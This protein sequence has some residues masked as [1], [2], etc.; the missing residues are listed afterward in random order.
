VTS[1]GQQATQ[2]DQWRAEAERALSAKEW[3]AAQVAIVR[4]R[5]VAP[6]DA[7]IYEIEARLEQVLPIQRVIDTKRRRLNER[8]LQAAQVGPLTDPAISMEIQDLESEIADLNKQVQKLVN[9]WPQP[10]QR[11]RPAQI[12]KR[13]RIDAAI[14][15]QATLGEHIYLVVQVRLPNSRP[16]RLED[17]PTQTKPKA[18]EQ[19]SESIS[20]RFQASP[21]TDILA[22][23]YQE[24]KIIAPDF[25]IE[26]AASQTVEIPQNKSSKSVM[27]LLTPKR[28]GHIHVHIEV[29]SV[30]GV[31]DTSIPLAVANMVLMVRVEPNVVA[32]LVSLT[33]VLKIAVGIGLIIVA[34][35]VISLISSNSRIPAQGTANTPTGAPTAAPVVGGSSVPSA[36]GAPTATAAASAWRCTAP[37]AAPTVITP[38]VPAA[39]TTLTGPFDYSQ[40]GQELA[41]AFAGNYKGKTVSVLHG[42]SGEEERK[43]KDTFT[44]FE[45][46]TGIT[47]TL[48]AGSTAESI[49]IKVQ[50]GTI[51]DIVNFPQPGAMGSYAK[52]GEIVDLNKFIEPDWLKQ[53]YRPGFIETNTVLD[54]SGK[55]ILGGVFNRI[56]L[57]SIVF[58]P[59]KAFDAC[60]YKVPTTWEEMNKLMKQIVKDGDTPWCIGIKDGDLDERTG[61]PATDW[62]ED[63]ML[64]TTTPLNY[65]KWITGT[66]AFT[67]TEVIT[68]VKLMSDIWFDDQYV[69]GGRAAIANTYF[70]DAPAPMMQDPPKCWLHHQATFITTFLEQ[71]KPGAKAGVDY[72][73]FYLPPFEYTLK[74]TDDTNDRPVLFAG[75]LFSMFHDRPEVRALIE[76]F[77]TYESIQPWIKQGGALSPH[78]N[79]TDQDYPTELERQAALIIRSATYVRFDGSDLMP[80]EVGTGTFWTGITNYV[81]GTVD[82]EQAMEEIQAGWANIK[83]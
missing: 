65:D 66:L 42:L 16:L 82:L 41:D 17:W 23:T 18:I 76:Y 59:K 14:P 74:D 57:K 38:P 34:L 9:D 15:S 19:A 51:E 39:T 40:I 27:F 5:A 21:S 77:T 3:D 7:A 73:F 70:G 24:I 20:S 12:V 48:V 55:M 83:R 45:A 64:R 31:I 71:A 10:N 78:L 2:A 75:D 1:D 44:D 35:F 54:K 79:S 67:S 50:N 29:Y 11:S 68:A 8:R 62:I 36:M 25:V 13:R 80:G 26:G 37:I 32:P 61:W 28:S 43:F 4:W 69:Y 46:K 30:D 56:N 6:G 22:S 53:N 60:G 58:Y 49:A 63:I 52:Q 33:S 72:D 81:R 47:V